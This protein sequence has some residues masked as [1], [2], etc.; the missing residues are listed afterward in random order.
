MTLADRIQGIRL[1]ALELGKELF[2]ADAIIDMLARL[3]NQVR[4]VVSTRAR[5]A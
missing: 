1:R 2:S 5:V 3:G 4:L